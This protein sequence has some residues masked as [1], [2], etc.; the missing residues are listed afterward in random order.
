MFLLGSVDSDRESGNYSLWTRFDLPL[1]FIN[2]VLFEHSHAHSHIV[3]GCF[4]PDCA[5]L[6]RDCANCKAEVF[7]TRPFR[8]KVCSPLTETVRHGNVFSEQCSSL[9]IPLRISL[10]NVPSLI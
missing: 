4:V 9:N 2:Q 5:D 7:T 6:S 3:Y 10:E 1:V 8:V